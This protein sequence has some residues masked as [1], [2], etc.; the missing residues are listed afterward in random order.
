MNLQYYLIQWKHALYYFIKCI[1]ISWVII[2][3]AFF[4]VFDWQTIICR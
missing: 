4:I 3:V 1:Q 2:G